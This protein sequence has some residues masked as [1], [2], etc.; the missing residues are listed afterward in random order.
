[1][2]KLKFF[3]PLAILINCASPQEKEIKLSQFYTSSLFHDVQLK[4]VF[5]DSKTFVDC[6][7]KKDLREIIKNYE[8]I[9]DQPDFDLVEFVNMNFDLPIRPKSTF[10]SDTTLIMEE[11][12]T[13]LWPILTRKADQIEMRSSLIP[14]PYD[15]VVPGGR[16]SEI[17]Y[18]DSYFTILGLKAQRR[19]DLIQKHGQELCASNRH[20]WIYS[21][22]KPELLLDAF[23][24]AIFFFNSKRTR[25]V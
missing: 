4:S 19:Y 17:Y 3:L 11:H 21:K 8:A 6:T 1:M 9:R 15:Y 18:W 24:A 22:W 7:P 14:L 5:P 13:R 23:P 20:H 10:A 12:L 2:F 25:R 16:F